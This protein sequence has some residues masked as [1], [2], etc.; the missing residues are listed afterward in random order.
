[1]SI[2][3]HRK[4]LDEGGKERLVT[5]DFLTADSKVWEIG[6]YHGWW[7]TEI[8]KKY[9]SWAKVFEPIWFEELNTLFYENPKIEIFDFGLSDCNGNQVI[10]ISAD[11]SGRFSKGKAKSIK[12]RSIAEMVCEKID[13]VQCNCEGGE[14]EIL[15]ELIETGLIKKFRMIVVQFHYLHKNH[16]KMRG[17]IQEGLSKTHR[18]IICYDWKFEY[19]ELKD[20]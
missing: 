16:P 19:W 18:Q 4:W 20:A 10:G 2:E 3:M 15:P 5:F 6:G 1:M 13:L 9:D 8:A 14:Y 11:G 17:D 7:V 12:V